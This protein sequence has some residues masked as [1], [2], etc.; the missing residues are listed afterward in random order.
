MLWTILFFGCSTSAWSPLNV[1]N[2]LKSRAIHGR[3]FPLG[4]RRRPEYY[5]Y[6]DDDDEYYK[7]DDD[8]EYYKDDESRRPPSI[9]F[10]GGYGYP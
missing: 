5:E 3:H 2:G 10:R 6:D 9:G 7:D 8:D 4:A 1:P